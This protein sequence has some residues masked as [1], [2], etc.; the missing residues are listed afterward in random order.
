MLRTQIIARV[1]PRSI[2][3]HLQGSDFYKNRLKKGKVSGVLRAVLW[4]S[5]QGFVPALGR[6]LKTPGC[7]NPGLSTALST[8]KRLIN[9]P[10]DSKG[11]ATS[12]PPA[13]GVYW[14]RISAAGGAGQGVRHLC[15]LGI[16]ANKAPEP[17]PPSS[18]LGG[19]KY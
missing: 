4:E 17:W 7:W 15:L 6:V 13:R 3:W 19:K 9:G 16:E 1:K 18:P 5:R 14:H 12:P 8:L 11:R 10:N 2:L